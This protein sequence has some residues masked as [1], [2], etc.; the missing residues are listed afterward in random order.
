MRKAILGLGLGMTALMVALLWLAPPIL[1]RAQ[2]AVFDGYQRAAPRA[3]DPE[4]PVHILDIDEA[5]LDLYGQWPWPRSYLAELTR[6]L[7]DHGA[8][9]VG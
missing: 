7:F 6:R 4:A 3:F 9:A 2:D 8:V 1:S 5:A